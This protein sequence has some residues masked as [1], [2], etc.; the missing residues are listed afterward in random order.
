MSGF[1]DALTLL[2]NVAH[3]VQGAFTRLGFALALLCGVVGAVSYLVHHASL[4]RKAH[5]AGA[6]GGRVVA[7][8]LL[9]GGLAG[10]DQ[11]MGAA[12]RQFG[13]QGATFEA[14]S[15]VDV[16]SFGVAAEAANA[17]LSLIRVFGIYVAL[18]GMLRWRRSLRDG[19]TGLSASEDV[20]TGTLKFTLG[21]MMV[22]IPYLLDALRR[23][24]G[25]L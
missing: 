16:G 4:A 9:C 25:L 24:L 18:Q 7:W 2:V 6:G 19:H 8:L 5:V 10:L 14:I 20:S 23:T 22:C 17:L 3:N 11:M 21:V 13:W 15:Y 12:A 1:P